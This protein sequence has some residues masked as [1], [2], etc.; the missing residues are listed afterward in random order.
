MLA[1]AQ[2]SSAKRG[3]LVVD[4]SSGLIFLTKNVMSIISQQRKGVEKDIPCQEKSK[5]SW[6]SYVNFRQSTLQNEDNYKDKE[7]HHIIIK[8][9][10]FQEHITILNM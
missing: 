5:E 7:R 4:V 3:G 6:S 8:E 10:I 2:S 9:S 1:Q